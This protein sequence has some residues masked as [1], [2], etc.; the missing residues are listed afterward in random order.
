MDIT[1]KKL[2]IDNTDTLILFG[3][4]DSNLRLLE[5]HFDATIIAR[6]N[7]LILKGDIT[8]IRS[9]EKVLN[10][11]Q[12]IIRR[13]G[14]LTAND[15]F[16]V[17]DLVSPKTP[18]ARD[19]A[20]EADTSPTNS[21]AQQASYIRNPE[22]RII[23]LAQG[24]SIKARTPTQQLY[25]EKVRT[26]DIVFGIG[27]AGTG[28]TY[29]AVAM[30]LALL[31][32]REVSRVILSRPAVDA[33][34]SLG[35]LPGDYMEKVDPYLRPL[36]DALAEMLTPDKLKSMMEKRIVEITP[37]AYMRGRTFNNSVII[38]DEAQNATVTQMKMFLTRMGRNSKLIITGDVTQIDLP[39]RS[40]SG[41][42]QIQEILQG[43]PGIAFVYFDKG[44]V[45]RHR[46]VADI[47][48]AYERYY[49]KHDTQQEQLFPHHQSHTA[50]A[51]A[52]AVG[53]SNVSVSS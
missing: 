6:G 35:F 48:D 31:R 10:E 1:E 13:T 53:S 5:N 22:E 19:A 42:V 16:T 14:T 43:I 41:L 23:F 49:R 46:L 39:R 9:I 37:L 47:I 36:T 8:E 30:A 51:L 34:E 52:S 25:F 7:T 11:L 44:D 17:M 29:L 15:V 50:E 24:E 3:Y 18:L 26:N 28:K 4:N 33:G 20:R 21:L 38:L 45:V 32:N 12:F 27:P 2:R 40:D